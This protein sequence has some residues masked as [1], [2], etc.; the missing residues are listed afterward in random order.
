[1]S[2]IARDNVLKIKIVDLLQYLIDTLEYGI[3]DDDSPIVNKERAIA[4]IA[5]LN[6]LLPINEV[7]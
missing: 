1:M 4:M 7:K 6:S 5:E 2:D 3:E